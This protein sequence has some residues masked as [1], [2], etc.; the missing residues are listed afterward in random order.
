LIEETFEGSISL[1][2]FC[3][4]SAHKLFDLLVAGF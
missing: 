2:L 3:V 4:T 1:A